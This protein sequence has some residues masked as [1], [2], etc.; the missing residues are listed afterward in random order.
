[1]PCSPSHLFVGCANGNVVALDPA[2][3]QACSFQAHTYRVFDSIYL[4]VSPLS[5]CL[6]G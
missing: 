2:L 1:V 4:Q 5:D 6:R 3:Q